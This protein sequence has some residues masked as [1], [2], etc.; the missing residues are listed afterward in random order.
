MKL[1]LLET[2]D[3]TQEDIAAVETRFPM[4]CNRARRFANPADGLAV[5]GSSVLL[6][7]VLGIDDENA[8]LFTCEG[9]PYLD[10][11]PCFGLSHSAGRCVLAVSEENIGVDIEKLDKSNLI[12]SPAALTEEELAWISPSPLE[13]FHILWTRKE[14]IYKAVGGFDDPKQISALEDRLQNGLRVKSIL[15]DGY[16]LSVCCIDEGELSPESMIRI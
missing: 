15:L 3:I 12:A 13:R 4:R 7:R 8:V 16:A 10:K 2:A 1:Y 11:G 9:K 5:I 6:F 14:S